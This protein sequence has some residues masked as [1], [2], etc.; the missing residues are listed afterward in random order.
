MTQRRREPVAPTAT[1][2]GPR[3]HDRWPP[4]ARSSG[5]HD[6][7]YSTTDLITNTTGAVIGIALE[8]VTPRLL[9]TKSHLLA[10]RD[11]ARPVTRRRRLLG[12]LLDSWF[13][14]LAAVLGG[15]IGSTVYAV[16]HGGPGQPLTPEQF[17]ALEQAIF[18]GAWI[19]AITTVVVPALI[20]TGGSLGQCTVYLAPVPRGGARWRLLLRALVVQ[21]AIPTGL[22]LGFP[23]ALLV[24]LWAAVAVVSVLID[25]RGLS[26][27]LTGCSLRD[28]RSSDPEV[29]AA[30]AVSLRDTEP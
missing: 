1:A 25:P 18:L 22:L 24:P 13:L 10:R 14:L 16:T 6:Y 5:S 19:A 21:G 17:L 26:C 30:S 29:R 23:A 12:M 27:A 4:K 28:A 9:S 7:E 11:H 3:R 15:T 8:K 20:S 2:T